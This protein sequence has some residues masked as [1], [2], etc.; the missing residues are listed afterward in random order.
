L[1]KNDGESDLQSPSPSTFYSDMR[2]FYFWIIFILTLVSCGPVAP[3]TPFLVTLTPAGTQ[4]LAVTDTASPKPE[5]ATPVAT[6]SPANTATPGATA[7]IVV[8]TPAPTFTFTPANTATPEPPTHTPEPTVDPWPVART[9]PS[10][11]KMGLHVILN[12]D[13]RIMEFI[14]RTQP[15]VVKG[16]D[17]LDWMAQVKQVS[18]Q[19]ITIGRFTDVPNRDVLD[20]KTPDQ[21]PNPSDFAHQFIDTF[22][23]RY[24]QYP[25]VDYWEGW[26][27]FPPHGPDQW[28]WFSQFEYYRACYMNQMGLKAAIGAFSAGTPEYTDM[29]IFVQNALQPEVRDNC[30]AI[31]TLHEYSSP[32]LQFGF[33]AGIPNAVHVDNAGSLTMRYRYWYEGFI[34]PAGFT[35]PLVITES[36]IDAGTGQGCPMGDGGQ[37]WYS[38]YKDWDAL[39]LGDA[40]WKVYLDQLAW[41]DNLLRQDPYVIGFTVFTA[42]TTHVPQWRTFDIDDLLVPMAG[43]MNSQ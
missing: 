38:C 29:G 37:G 22:I 7:T 3:V 27:E 43:Y 11:S 13:P 42:G 8:T 30:N 39:N 17:N 19:T 21:F 20:N 12:D 34:K 31:F 40:K 32:T 33:N 36:G 41:Y 6:A 15:K 9:S 5:T 18:P 35:I 24:R 16:L 4:H 1:E 26:N 10:A 28:K 23:E 25:S 2:R 14:K